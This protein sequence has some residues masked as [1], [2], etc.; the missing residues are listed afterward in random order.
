MFIPSSDEESVV[1]TSESTFRCEQSANAD[2]LENGYLQIWLYAMRHYPL[3]PPDPKKDDDLLAKSTRAK[4]DERAIYEMAKLARRLGF[5]SP[6][7]KAII[8]WSNFH[9]SY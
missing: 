6:E 5:E 4:A 3:M 7:I 2:G 1:Q 8:P 9:D